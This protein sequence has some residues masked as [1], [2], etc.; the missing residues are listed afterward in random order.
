MTRRP[1][2]TGLG[3]EGSE[4]NGVGND[5]VGNEPGEGSEAGGIG[6][7]LEDG[8]GALLSA[9]SASFDKLAPEPPEEIHYITMGVIAMPDQP[10][11]VP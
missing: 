9:L 10:P 2:G 1:V 3:S 6:A 8:V 5:A 11:T 4:R 7:A